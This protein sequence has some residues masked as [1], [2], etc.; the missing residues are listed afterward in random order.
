MRL[1]ALD[2]EQWRRIEVVLDAALELSPEE[3]PSY[4]DRACAGEPEL[5]EQ[6]EV[7]LEADA[8]AG[9]FLSVPAAGELV[10]AA[11]HEASAVETI[12]VSKFKTIPISKSTE[13]PDSPPPDRLG[14]YSVLGEMGRGGMGV[15]HLGRDETLGR[16]VAIKR[17]PER[18][19]RDAERLGRFLREAKLLAAL[20]H[21]NI[22]TI[23]GVE[24]SAGGDRFLILERA[25]GRTLGERLKEPLTV[26]Q[27][28]DVCAQIAAALGAAH[29]HGIIHRDLKP[30]NVM[31]SSSGLVKVLDFGLAKHIG[32]PVSRETSSPSDSSSGSDLTEPGTQLGTPG[33]MSPEQ[34]L[35][36]P[37]T[38]RCDV[39]SFG[40]VLYQ[41]LTGQRAFG[42]DSP[43]ER[44]G[45][46]LALPVNLSRLPA[47]TPVPV[48]EMLG[49]CLEK[50]PAARLGD[51]GEAIA[52]LGEATG[53]SHAPA[54]EAERAAVTIAGLTAPSNPF[55]GRAHEIDEI[56]RLLGRARLVTLTGAGGCGK[57]R[58]AIEVARAMQPG[59][60]GGVWFVDLAPIVD[61]ETV[62]AIV[63][64]TLGVPERAGTSLLD[65]IAR[66]LGRGP[67]L[68]VL[69][70]CEH[71]IAACASVAARLLEAC[72]E[73]G[74]LATSREWLGV[75]GEQTWAV[76]PLS[77]PD[78]ER[79]RGL[80]SIAG[81]EAVR[82]FVDRARAARRD[83]RLE[84]SNSQ[85]VARIC[86]SLD[87]IPLGIELAAARV[88]DQGLEQIAEQHQELDRPGAA[89]ASR[90]DTLRS[91]IRWSY[92]QL[93]E[94]E[95]RLFGA[96]AVFT[97]GWTLDSAAAVCTEDADEFGALDVLTRLVDKS[98][99]VIERADRVEPRY[100]LLEPIRQ[101]A[102]ASLAGAEQAR[103]G[104]RHLEHFLGWAERT[105]PSLAS[106]P[107]SAQTAARLEADH[108]NLLAAIRWCVQ[109][110][111]ARQGLRLAG[112]AWWF[113]HVRGH[114]TQGRD[115]LARV[116]ALPD[117]QSPTA[118]RAVALYG[119]GGL[120]AYQGDY[121]SARRLNQEALDL[122]RSLGDRLGIA[123]S[124]THLGIVA[125][126][127]G[128]HDEAR[129]SYQEA[130]SIFHELGDHR[131]LA[132]TLNNLGALARQ[133]GRYEE[134]LAACEEAVTHARAS[135]HSLGLHVAH[136]NLGWVC[137]RL[138]R[139][140]E[141]RDHARAMLRVVVDLQARRAAP[142]GLEI[143]AE[144]LARLGE[145]EDAAR[146]MGAAE[147]LRTA[148]TMPRDA[149][150]RNA[151]AEATDRL[152][153][154]LGAARFE[155]LRSEGAG[156]SF[157]IA[158]ERALERIGASRSG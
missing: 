92:G 80:E 62:P 97:G 45:A 54:S 5:R 78:A 48:R 47:E 35:G 93:V 108:S 34:I 124:H 16:T 69:D 6:V 9:S 144:V 112:A 113:W 68:V 141:A 31:V 91:T 115:A 126:G 75:P 145:P 143:A 51:I 85:L 105:A 13:P 82:L 33:Y 99:V 149:W 76:A 140:T 20:H 66:A 131:R 79:D 27:A 14:R 53:E 106:G 148:M 129:D 89:A 77:V 3:I 65:S 26:A 123:R 119:A 12:P 7:L 8:R 74:I 61:A 156:W 52:V 15:V 17:L 2:G 73:L 154:T 63:A 19:V 25:E 132:T 83:F 102:A 37:H 56:A 135:G 55:I 42:G 158:L 67:A 39:F 64:S 36:K 142:A 109:R 41:C 103:L 23:H 22:A 95:R 1:G 59:R 50:D 86:R 71:L 11:S 72:P 116:L 43:F 104:D 130:L 118:E 122:F 21:P 147:T 70:N 94:D 4:L 44:I 136:Q 88:R 29:A 114:F 139:T 10:A 28:L 24:Q 46:T 60:P 32:Q 150:W 155:T 128:R 87:G 134:A 40:C 58:L 151:Q 100:R 90:H 18:F 57:T 98:L 49:R 137:L 117:A 138:G 127:E 96:L 121:E 84:P 107:E 153:A 133:Q 110:G 111:L 81:T 120:A 38:T 146:L 125:T 157:E 30:G 152:I 101:F